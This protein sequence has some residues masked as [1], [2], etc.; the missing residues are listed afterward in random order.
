MR[1][2]SNIKPTDIS[3]S[4]LDP[5]NYDPA[6][7]LQ[8]ACHAFP[9]SRKVFID[10]LDPPYFAWQ[11]KVEDKL[12]GYYV[13]LLAGV[14][15]TLMDIG[16]ARDFRGNGLGREL[17]KHF[18]LECNKRQALD[19]WLEVRVSNANAIS[20]YH[21]MGFETIETR[22]NYYPLAEG[23]EDASIMKMELGR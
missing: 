14:E 16:V 5:N 23:K 17:V 7:K 20:L 13:G 21:S 6:F 22:K 8:T 9:W 2:T 18:L 15:A 4:P 1:Q 10:C 11:V 12:A 19:A 3:F